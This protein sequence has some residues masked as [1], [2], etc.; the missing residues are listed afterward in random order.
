MVILQR[1]IALAVTVSAAMKVTKY[2][3]PLTVPGLPDLTGLKLLYAVWCYQQCGEP[4]GSRLCNEPLKEI[5]VFADCVSVRREHCDAKSEN[6]H[7]GL[8]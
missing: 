6:V 2:D 3:K 5:G 8:V 7:G 4:E 1:V